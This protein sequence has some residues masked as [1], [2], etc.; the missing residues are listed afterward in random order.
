MFFIYAK[1]LPIGSMYGISAN[2]NGVFVDG[3]WQTIYT[4]HTDP[5]GIIPYTIYIYIPYI[6]YIPYIYHI[7]TISY[8]IYIP[9]IP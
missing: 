9:Y 6:P 4:I 2:M 5:M 3:K 7:Y 1:F 8:K